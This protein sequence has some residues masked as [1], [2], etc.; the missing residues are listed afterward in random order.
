ME[1]CNS[2]MEKDE[3]YFKVLF[4]ELPVITNHTLHVSLP[5]G[6]GG[7]RENGFIWIEDID[8]SFL[9]GITGQGG[10]VAAGVC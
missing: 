8:W 9:A 2:R 10:R 1:V 5:L 3:K 4:L 7:G 6:T